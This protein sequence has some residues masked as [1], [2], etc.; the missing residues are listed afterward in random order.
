[1]LYAG[2]TCRRSYHRAGDWTFYH[3][4]NQNPTGA[5]AELLTADFNPLHW[6]QAKCYG[7]FLCQR[8]SL[9][10]VDIQITYYQVDT[11]EIIR[12][13]RTFSAEALEDFLTDTLR[14][15]TPW[16]HMEA[17]WRAT[18]NAS[19]KALRF[20]FPAYRPGQYE[21]AGAVY[22]TIAG[23]GRL[24]CA[25]PTGI[26]KTVSTLFPALK[27]LGEEKGRAHFLLDGKNHYKAGRRG[28]AGAS[29]CSQH[30][31]RHTAAS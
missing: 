10:G 27:A 1:M 18:R 25:A 21:M 8:E 12:H 3:R 4:R 16:A 29:A 23:G 28:C 17:A 14:L 20:P 11:D 24:F 5:P 30:I 13:R 15:Y 26:G 2:G 22:R 9:P 31:L 19:L 6:A 7:A